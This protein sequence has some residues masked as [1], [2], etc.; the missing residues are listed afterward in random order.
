MRGSGRTTGYVSAV[1]S[2]AHPFLHLTNERLI[3]I[4]LEDIR[5]VY[6]RPGRLLRSGVIKEKRATF[7][8]TCGVEKFRPGAP[9]PFRNLFLAGDWTDTGLPATIEGAVVSGLTAAR[10]IR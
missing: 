4:A 8:P 5:G 2:A 9:T 10:M 7:S 3:E 6:P 1:I